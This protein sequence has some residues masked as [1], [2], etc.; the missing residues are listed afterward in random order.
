MIAESLVGTLAP[1]LTAFD[2]ETIAT[3]RS[4]AEVPAPTGAETAR[5]NVVAAA[6]TAMGCSVSRDEAGNVMTELSGEASHGPVVVCAHLDTVFPTSVSHI[7]RSAEARLVGPGIGDN[8]RG[9]AGMLAMIRLLTQQPIGTR[10]PLLFVATVGEEGCG[11]LA[12]ARHLFSQRAAHACA[13]VALDGAG[14]ERI[15]T[16]AVGVQRFRVTYRGPGGHSW[17]SSDA[18]NPLTAAAQLTTSISRLPLPPGPRT[19]ISV[20]T[21]HGGS[22]VNAIP[23]EAVLEVDARSLSAASLRALA[24][25]LNA[26]AHRACD[27]ENDRRGA[28]TAPLRVQVEVTSER[29]GGVVDRDSLL[30]RSAIDATKAIG[31]STEFAMASTDANIPLSL[32]IPAITLGAGGAGGDTH[33]S[34]EWFENTNGPRG[35]ARAL[36]TILLTAGVRA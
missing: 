24:L 10:H 13:A 26:L 27:D 34:H 12:G 18:P 6:L 14:D 7:I 16:H 5:G 17:A 3:Q 29:P 32:G 20:T 22:A 35:I 11:N 15:V 36:A 30:V 1:V 9:L 23:G 2:N 21:V 8:A 19:T 28:Q 4:L 31:R 33:T 25:D